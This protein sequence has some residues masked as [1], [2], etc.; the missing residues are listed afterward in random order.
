MARRDQTRQRDIATIVLA[1]TIASLALSACGRRGD[2]EPP[3]SAAVVTTDEQGRPIK[4][5]E[6]PVSDRPFVLDALIQ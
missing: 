6:A 3:P 2:P 5:S 4:S 1:M